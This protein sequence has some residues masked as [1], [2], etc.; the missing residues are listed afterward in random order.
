M[1]INPQRVSGILDIRFSL[2]LTIFRFVTHPEPHRFHSTFVSQ[3][4]V[5]GEDGRG[6]DGKEYEIGIAI[7]W[8]EK[9]RLNLRRFFYGD[10][11]ENFT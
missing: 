10:E 5:V 7:L 9:N 2:R 4:M 8:N 3:L 1:Y 6:E 11:K